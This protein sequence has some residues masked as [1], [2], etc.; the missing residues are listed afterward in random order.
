MARGRLTASSASARR[1]LAHRAERG[2]RVAGGA[3]AAAAALSRAAAAPSSARASHE[4]RDG[5]VVGRGASV[6]RSIAS[7]LA[8]RASSWSPAANASAPGDE[9]DAA[10][11]VRR[12]EQRAGALELLERGARLVER[13]AL[14]ARAH[15]QLQR[16]HAAEHVGGR[17]PAQDALG[18]VGGV[19]RAAVVQRQL[20][21]PEHAG[22]AGALV[23]RAR[24]VGAALA[25]AQLGE[26][27]EP[28]GGLARPGRLEVGDR[29]DQ[30][31]LGA[32]PV[33]AGGEHAA[34]GAAADADQLAR[35]PALGDVAHDHAPLRRAREVADAVAGRDQ[36]AERPALREREAQLLD[37]GDRGRLVEQPHA[38]GD[39]AADHLG[40]PV[41]REPDRLEVGD[42]E[43]APEPRGEARVPRGAPPGRARR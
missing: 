11:Q 3:R 31:A 22:R 6:R 39:A 10:E 4:P 18:G 30:L 20:A 32:H 16:G 37:G 8:R 2:E 15:E 13:A 7:S 24:L 17:Q 27:R 41:Q 35:A 29:G 19:R 38:L 36:V 23:Q 5:G 28:A 33:A 26:P 12:A 1:E 34:V 9:P 43:L 40:D 21:E 42:A 25:R 14:R